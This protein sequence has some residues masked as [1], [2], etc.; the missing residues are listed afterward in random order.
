MPV[1]PERS[2]TSAGQLRGMRERMA[3]EDEVVDSIALPGWQRTDGYA[4]LRNAFAFG[5]GLSRDVAHVGMVFV[6]ERRVGFVRTGA[7]GATHSIDRAAL[8]DCPKPRRE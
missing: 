6:G 5:G 8:R 7:A 4:Q 3:P 1:H 2:G